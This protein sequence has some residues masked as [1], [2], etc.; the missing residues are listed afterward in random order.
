MGVLL[1]VIIA[2]LGDDDHIVK[3]GVLVTLV[4]L[5][6]TLLDTIL[7]LI[8]KLVSDEAAGVRCALA[9]TAG[10][11]LVHCHRGD[12]KDL[13]RHMDATL[14]P[15]I[16]RLLHDD[17]AEV[18][19]AALRAVSDATSYSEMRADGGPSAKA[20]L[21]E[22]H[23]LRLLPTLRHLTT[24]PIWRVRSSAVEI[25]PT[26]LECTYKL[27]VRVE[28]AQLC[29]SL[30]NDKVDCVRTMAAEALCGGK[31]AQSPIVESSQ[32][33]LA[34]FEWIDLVVLPHLKACSQSQ[35]YR[36]RLLSFKIIRALFRHSDNLLSNQINTLPKLRQAIIGILQTLT[37]DPVAN[38]RLNIGRILCNCAQHFDASEHASLT[39][40][41]EDLL[42]LETA[43]TGGGDRDVRLFTHKARVYIQNLYSQN[44]EQEETD[45]EIRKDSILI[46]RT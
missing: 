6:P 14:L 13:Q 41:L 36:Q 3:I 4:D 23:V 17:D 30:L 19:S 24:N 35:D 12:N 5:E 8:L 31:C 9:R 28:I 46:D 42:A 22:K 34:D 16:Q 25:V 7:P 43:K 27:D 33:E 26:L 10:Q 39:C 11:L 2:L 29:I 37:T 20:I 15:L 38:V 1:D 18:T 40:I 44:Y 45:Q 32:H 21:T